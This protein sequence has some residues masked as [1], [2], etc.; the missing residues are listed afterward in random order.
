[1][2]AKLK[3]LM[4]GLLASTAI[5]APHAALAQDQDQGAPQ[6]VET[7]VVT[8][9]FIP[10]EKRATSEVA[11][12]LDSDD[13]SLSGDSDIASALKRVTGLSTDEGFVFVR[14][15]N[16]RYTRVLLNGVTVPSNE[17]LTRVVPVDIFP[18]SLIDS[19]LVQKTFSPQYPG[20][21]GGGVLELRTKSIPD[22]E[23]LSIGL[24]GTYNTVTN[25]E[26]GL[27]AQG[28]A[29]DWLGADFGARRFDEIIPD[30][31]ELPN[32]TEAELE[33]IGESFRN[34][35]SIDAETLPP[36]VG[37]NVSYG[38]SWNLRS[39]SRFG[40]VI[41]ADYENTWETRQGTRRSVGAGDEIE[42]DFSP[43]NEDCLLLGLDDCGFTRTNQTV[44]LNGLVSFGLEIDR[45]NALEFT[46]AILRKTTL[47]SLIQQGDG[48]E[49]EIVQDNRIDYIERQTWTNIVSGEHYWSI[50]PESAGFLDTEVNW[51]FSYSESKR[52]VED[53][54][55]ILFE[56]EEQVDAFAI[57]VEAI[58]DNNTITFAA[59]LDDTFE[60]GIDFVQPA[61][62]FGQA[63]DF[64]FG[65]QYINQQR[66]SLFREFGFIPPP[67]FAADFDLRTQ[68]PE[69][70]FGPVNI[71]PLGFEIT[72]VTDPQNFFAAEDEIFAGYVQV[73]A[74]VTDALRVAAG[75]RYEDSSQLAINTNGIADLTCGTNTFAVD[76]SEVFAAEC[77]GGPST[78]L[79]PGS[80]EFPF[81]PVSVPI[82]LQGEF[83]LPTV[84][85]TYEF[86]PN[87][88]IRFGYSQTVNRPSLRERSLGIFLEPDRDTEIVGNPF[89]EIAEIDNFDL[90]W[91]WYFAADQFFTLAGFYKEIT[92]PIEQSIVAVP[93]LTRSFINAEQAELVGVE[94]ELKVNLPFN[95]WWPALGNR[96]FFFFGNGSY[97]DSDVTI[98]PSQ[99]TLL[100]S[101]SRQLQ[102]QSEF[103]GNIQFGYEDA[104]AGE[105]AVL[106]VNYTGPRI[107]SVGAFGAPDAIETPPVLVD[108]VASK[109]FEMF[110]GTYTWSF[111][112]RNLLNDDYELE[113][114]NV[115]IEQF[116]L[117]RSFGFGVTAN[118]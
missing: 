51:Y 71:D 79:F 14:G 56:F 63:V 13:L 23:F 42:I 54:R 103:L 111:S 105:K 20:D 7:L 91:E 15:L 81:D 98:D 61:T 2:N 55:D 90:R 43:G 49:D 48:A 85:V 24:S 70:I 22:E 87:N 31:G 108:F 84:T 67:G 69:I 36:D 88:Q 16:E 53:R 65:G 32:A 104:D 37:L 115:V 66:D 59:L 60:G 101:D 110:G 5:C 33:V 21:F 89:L 99:A 12:L 4:G 96:Q 58:P 77:A 30:V 97:I 19:V 113:Q 93:E 27:T 8:G 57:A 114:G 34:V 11:D 80:T 17:P 73:D 94:A 18:T 83:G 10:D 1:M 25:L 26:R 41:V 112:A 40:F 28:G 44:N 39:E 116:D 82:D 45:D 35:G 6:G 117:G 75:F 29:F 107:E 78:V 62:I 50:L 74:Q 3:T 72:E 118:Y 102:G 86:L 76:L 95:E 109:D 106:Q 47:Q 38:N 9:Q 92:N 46:T 100:T 64:K 68:V 52:D